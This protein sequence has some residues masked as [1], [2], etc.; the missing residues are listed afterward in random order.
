MGRRPSDG[1]R[2]RMDDKGIKMYTYQH[3]LHTRHA[4][5]V[6]YKHELKKYK[7][8]KTKSAQSRRA[9]TRRGDWGEAGQWVSHS[10]VGGTNSWVP[11]GFII[12]K[13]IHRSPWGTH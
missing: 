7:E 2:R 11:P 4:N 9:V 10:L 13:G 3:Q 6:H 8:K 1:W 5:T 12:R